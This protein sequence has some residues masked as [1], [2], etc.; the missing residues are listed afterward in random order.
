MD[1]V[2]VDRAPLVESC[3]LAMFDYQ[4]DPYLGCEH[5]CLYCYT[6]NRCPV[7]WNREVGI[8]PDFP[9]KAAAELAPLPPQTVYLG[10][11]TD[12]YQPVEEEYEHTRAV[13]ELL[14]ARGS[15]ACILTKASLAMR[16]IDLL[17]GMSDASIGTSLA[18]QDDDTVRV[19]EEKTIPNRERIEM[20]AQMHEAGITTYALINPVVPLIT[21]V[22]TLIDRVRPHVETLWLYR[23]DM[24][25]ED[26]TNWRRTDSILEHHF[27]EIRDDVKK[28]V[29]SPDHEYWRR[30]R[31]ELAEL[32]AAAEIDL[33]IHI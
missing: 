18:F 13:L 3:S 16:D 28:I 11:N 24:E 17:R 4:I 7:D 8:D 32:G 25:S 20:L 15:S 6:Q 27:P 2:P 21:D 26:D 31:R 29:F 10:M 9:K 12:P 1:V 22:R 14:A 23:L 19:F 30:L 5:H 33:E